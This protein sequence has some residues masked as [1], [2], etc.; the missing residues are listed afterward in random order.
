MSRATFDRATRNLDPN[1]KLPDLS[2]PAPPT[3]VGQVPVGIAA[4]VI[5]MATLLRTASPRVSAP[6]RRT[7]PV[8]LRAGRLRPAQTLCVAPRLTPFQ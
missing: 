4:P 2:S 7:Q 6:S 8:F 1:L 5:R 3:D